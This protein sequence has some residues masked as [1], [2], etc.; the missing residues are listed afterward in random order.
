MSDG[1]NSPRSSKQNSIKSLYLSKNFNSEKIRGGK[2]LLGNS[3]QKRAK[4]EDPNNKADNF[5]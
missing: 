5:D 2:G 1:Y 4:K 3:P